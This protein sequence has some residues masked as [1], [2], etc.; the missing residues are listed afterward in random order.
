MPPIKSSP[1]VA[2]IRE[3][4]KKKMY[5]PLYFQK[6]LDLVSLCVIWLPKRHKK[7]NSVENKGG[8]KL[9]P[10]L[11][12][13]TLSLPAVLAQGTTNHGGEKRVKKRRVMEHGPSAIFTAAMGGFRECSRCEKME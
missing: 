2:E 7:E 12:K 6:A 10:S 1:N 4:V 11:F 5:F 3:F 9:S 13:D 8:H